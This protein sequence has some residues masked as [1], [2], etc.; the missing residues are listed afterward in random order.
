MDSLLHLREP[1]PDGAVTSTSHKILNK[2]LIC[3]RQIPTHHRKQWTHRPNLQLTPH[4]NPK[5]SLV[6]QKVNPH[7]PTSASANAAVPSKTSLP[8]ALPGALPPPPVPARRCVKQT[9]TKLSS[10]LTYPSLELIRPNARRN[11]NVYW[12]MTNRCLKQ[13]ALGRLST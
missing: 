11:S 12:T 10:T 7:H 3:S 9:S 6:S 5:A 8:T 2:I 13:V 4:P 1:R